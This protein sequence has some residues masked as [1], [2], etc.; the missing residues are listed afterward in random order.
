MPP[1]DLTPRNVAR[2][3][4]AK[5]VQLADVIASQIGDGFLRPNENLPSEA[6]IGEQAG[7]SKSVVRQALAQLA[8]NGLIETRNGMPARV[9]APG[10]V[11]VISDARY[12]EEDALIAAGEPAVSSAFTR[13]HHIAWDDYRIKF[14]VRHENATPKDAEL[15]RIPLD[16]PVVRRHFVKFDADGEPVEIQNSAITPEVAHLCPW[17]VKPADQPY[18]G[19]T[20]RELADG[21]LRVDRIVQRVKARFPTEHEKGDLRISEVSVLDIE[22]VLWSRGPDGRQP[23][24]PVEA[25]RVILLASRHELAFDVT[26]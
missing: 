11:R 7:L 4:P 14:E 8:R 26:L 1:L 9:T 25:S 23:A 10:R 3:Q 5:Y 16:T 6:K 24:R 20:Q 17:M 12:R 22:R 2:K 15:L 18:P 21:G 13:G 19:G